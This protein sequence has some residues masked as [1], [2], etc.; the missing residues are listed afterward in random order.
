MLV[1]LG[2]WL[3]KVS[4]LW[5]GK[6]P[7]LYSAGC[8]GLASLEGSAVSGGVFLRIYGFGMALASLYANVQSCAPV[9]L[10]DWCGL[11]GTEAYWLLGGAWS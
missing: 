2:Q 1:G 10:R 6:D 5:G 11:S 4:W 8:L 3:V 9:F 7:C